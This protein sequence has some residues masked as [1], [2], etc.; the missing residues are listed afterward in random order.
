MEKNHQARARGSRIIMPMCLPWLRD[1]KRTGNNGKSYINLQKSTKIRYKGASLTTSVS[2]ENGPLFGTC[3]WFLLLLVL[4]FIRA[5]P[6][7]LFQHT[8]FPKLNNQKKRVMLLVHHKISMSEPGAPFFTTWMQTTW[9]VWVTVYHLAVRWER[10]RLLCHVSH[11]LQEGR[12]RLFCC[13][14]IPQSGGPTSSIFFS[15]QFL[16]Q[17]SPSYRI[18]I[19]YLRKY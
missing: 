9:I 1:W 12:G 18:Y 6:I 16:M 2:P 7:P 3:H 4:V 14:P 17:S 19:K 10:E 5:T 11:S 15:H 13:L 8:F